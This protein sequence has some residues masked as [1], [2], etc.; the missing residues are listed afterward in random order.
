MCLPPV[1]HAHIR[2]S[3]PLLALC[4]EPRVTGMFKW[5]IRLNDNRESGQIPVNDEFL[6]FG[7]SRKLT[8]FNRWRS[9]STSTA[10]PTFPKGACLAGFRRI[11]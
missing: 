11:P 2:G 9:N 3:R 1:Y 6:N 4:D 10:L 7:A 5:L 8:A